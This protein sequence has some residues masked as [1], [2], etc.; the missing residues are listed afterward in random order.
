ML[1][2]LPWQGR[3]ACGSVA[4]RSG[5]RMEALALRCRRR[6]GQWSWRQT[7][8][9]RGRFCNRLGRRLDRG[10]A[11]GRATC[12]AEILHFA[13]VG[14]DLTFLLLHR[15]LLA[16]TNF[17]AGGRHQALV[18]GLSHQ[19][20][21]QA[22]SAGVARIAVA[23]FTAPLAGAATEQALVGR[24]LG[25]G[26]AVLLA[27]HDEARLLDLLGRPLY[28]ANGQL[29][30]ARL[31]AMSTATQRTAAGTLVAFLGNEGTGC[32]QEGKEGEGR[33]QGSHDLDLRISRADRGLIG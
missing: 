24:A 25:L 14:R 32:R 23:S 12:A 28:L 27:L 5:L 20:V 30:S 21:Q 3:D 15:Q 11:A 22:A 7:A 6:R 1:A 9:R 29:A 10:G 18:M 26:E 2:G 16:A 19:P 13:G 31:S 33:E 4:P 17:S 8:G